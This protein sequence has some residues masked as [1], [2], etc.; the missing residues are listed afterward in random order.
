MCVIVHKRRTCSGLQV[1]WSTICI[2]N[3]DDIVEFVDDT[4]V[5]GLVENGDESAYRRE[6]IE[7]V[8]WCENN[9]LQLNT[10]KTKEMT[11]DFQK[12]KKT[13]DPLTINGAVTETVDCFNFFGT[14]ISNNLGWDVNVE[15]TVKKAQQRRFFLRQIKKVGLR[16]EILIQFYNSALCV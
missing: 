2:S 15:M 11:L 12:K 4:T 8:E 1:T 3:T 9:N 13:I 6:V 16:R 10:S 14:T 5:E 7:V